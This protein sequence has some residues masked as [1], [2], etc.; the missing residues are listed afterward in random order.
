VRVRLTILAA[1]ATMLAVA[2]CT[3]SSTGGPS[4]S[5]PAPSP[6]GITPSTPVAPSTQAS[7]GSSTRA[8][9][10]AALQGAILLVGPSAG[11]ADAYD[12]TVSGVSRLTTGAA[13]TTVT[14][15][16]KRIVVATSTRIAQLHGHTLD[17][18]GLGSAFS[19]ALSPSDALAWVA[20]D[21]SNQTPGI[22]KPKAFV[23]R[24]RTSATA[25]P[26]TVLRTMSSLG[27]LRWADDHALVVAE[28]DGTATRIVRIATASGGSGAGTTLATIDQPDA[29]DLTAGTKWITA[30][31]GTHTTLVPLAGGATRTLPA[32][33]VPLC[34]TGPSTLVT[35]SGSRLASASIS[36]S[37]AVTSTRPLA[38]VP[39]GHVYAADCSRVRS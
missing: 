15:D 34:W 14:A 5:P 12:V 23:V 28:S 10:P 39:G 31:Q 36:S 25:A 24:L 29:L 20:L 18:L 7:T 2:G 8:P 4:S 19:P 1:A 13:L 38:G 22:T 33:R 37:G 32:G 26:R 17:G 30:T 3:S 35:V 21:L 16:R 6:S 27:G 9:A 11:H